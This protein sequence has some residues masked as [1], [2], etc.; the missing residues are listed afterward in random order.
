MP[1]SITQHE[2]CNHGYTDIAELLLNNG[3]LINTPG[4][5]NDSPLHDAVSNN[6]VDCVR[7]LV[8]RGASQTAR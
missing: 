4:M 2:A 5:E 8:S 7:L 3:A 1:Y 6:R